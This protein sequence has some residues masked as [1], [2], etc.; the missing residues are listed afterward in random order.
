MTDVDPKIWENP[1]LGAAGAG[2]FLDEVE[3]QAKEDYN[4]RREGREPRVAYHVDRYP[5]L[6]HA[7]S[8]PSSVTTLVML[9]PGTLVDSLP[10]EE[11]VE[12]EVNDFDN[13]FEYDDPSVETDKIIEEMSGN[14]NSSS[15]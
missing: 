4:A 7:N 11:S 14:D 2:P 6:M 1:T 5:K 3:M 15:E 10:V 12:V 9:P 8:V 13:D